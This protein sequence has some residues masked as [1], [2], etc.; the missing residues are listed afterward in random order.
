MRNLNEH[1]LEIINVLR[2]HP[3][4]ATVETLRKAMGLPHA[5]Q[6]KP[7]RNRIDSA[8]RAGYNIVRIA[9]NTFQLHPGV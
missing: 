8:R 3:D 6:H 5:P 4:G 7:V 1:E 2:R 9:P